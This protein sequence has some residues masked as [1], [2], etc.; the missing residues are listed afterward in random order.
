MRSIARPSG[1]R[2][3]A[4]RSRAA[5]RVNRTLALARRAAAIAV[6]SD[7][8]SSPIHVEPEPW[9]LGACPPSTSS[10]ESSKPGALHCT[11]R[12]PSC[13]KRLIGGNPIALSPHRLPWNA[14]PRVV[15]AQRN[16]ASAAA[17]PNRSC[18]PRAT[19][20]PLQPR[21]KRRPRLRATYQCLQTHFDD[22]M[23]QPDATCQPAKVAGLRALRKPSP[24]NQAAKV[25]D[26][27]RQEHRIVEQQLMAVVA[28]D[29]DFPL[30]APRALAKNTRPYLAPPVRRTTEESLSDVMMLSGMGP[31]RRG[32]FCVPAP[33]MKTASADSA[34][35]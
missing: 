19:H 8:T 12:K 23:E 35:L 5:S 9:G 33:A 13:R 4:R 11:W 7:P 28:E 2:S 6:S 3:T 21:V 16:S 17:S 27:P 34:S 26:V 22:F 20:R 15:S 29:S 18:A 10:I 32:R 30:E 25:L 1:S 14:D 31:T 24:D